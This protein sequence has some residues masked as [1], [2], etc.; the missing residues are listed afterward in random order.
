MTPSPEVSRES[1]TRRRSSTIVVYEIL[2]FVAIIALSWINELLGLPSL[3]IGTDHLGGWHESLLETSIILLVAIPVVILTR[4]LVVRLHYLEE[5]LRLCAWCRKLHLDGE[6]VPVEEFVQRKFDTQTSH[7]ICPTCR[8]EQRKV[9][10][11]LARTTVPHELR[12]LPTASNWAG[13]FTW[14]APN[15][16]VWA[17]RCSS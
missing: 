12:P 4:R 3:I 7:G 8:A 16:P 13:G 15:A 6:W 11:E 14:L 1:A 17:P 10:G 2:G 5:F 9:S